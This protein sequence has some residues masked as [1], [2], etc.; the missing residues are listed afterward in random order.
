MAR[1]PPK[2]GRS[3]ELPSSLSSAAR[4]VQPAG[5]PEPPAPRAP[6]PPS[7]ASQLP[8]GSWPGDAKLGRPRF[9][10]GRQA[11]TKLG[12]WPRLASAGGSREAEGKEGRGG[13]GAGSVG[14][15]PRARRGVAP[16]PGPPTSPAGGPGCGASAW[17]A[18]RPCPSG[19]ARGLGLRGQCGGPFL[20]QSPA[21][22]GNNAARLPG[23]R[24]AQP[25]REHPRPTP[26]PARLAG[27]AGVWGGGGSCRPRAAK[28]REGGGARG[29]GG[30]TGQRGGSAAGEDRLLLGP[31]QPR[32]PDSYKPAPRANGRSRGTRSSAWE[33]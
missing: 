28:A 2:S 17:L 12:R 1:A 24:P 27:G 25:T 13:G 5:S 19:G 6:S 23:C 21:L 16:G 7:H 18:R 15:A 20:P 9:A 26:R 22:A 14:E 4:S 33:T 8:P 29:E 32:P 31:R 10:P 11:H 3:V 30:R